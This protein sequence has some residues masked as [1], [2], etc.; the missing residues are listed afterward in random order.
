MIH[1]TLYFLA[2]LFCL[3]LTM[4]WRAK[5]IIKWRGPAYL[6]QAMPKLD[7]SQLE[8]VKKKSFI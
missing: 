6:R 7:L 2:L 8:A 1:F 4:V 5:R 3:D